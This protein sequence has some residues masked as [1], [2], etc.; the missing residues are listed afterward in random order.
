MRYRRCVEVGYGGNLVAA[1][2]IQHMGGSVLCIDRKIF[3]GEGQIRT[4]VDDITHPDMKLYR[5]SDCIYAIRPGIEMM[6]DLIDLATTVASDLLIYHLG[7][8]L[9]HNGGE[10]IDCGVI[11]HRYHSQIKS[12]SEREEC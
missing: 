11:L 5:G 10:R 8:E 7:C 1:S 9:Y 4:A 6:P 12:Y 2:I 3:S